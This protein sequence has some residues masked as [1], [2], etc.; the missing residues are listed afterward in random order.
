M[1]KFL[2][3]RFKTGPKIGEN[4][5]SLTYRGTFL[6]GEKQVIIK[7]YK[8]GTLNSALIKN[9]KAKVKLLS[10]ID[11]PGIAKLYDG[12]YGWQGFYYVRE[13]VEG[14]TLG[15]AELF[16]ADRIIGLVCEA[17][18][19]P[20]RAGLVHGAIKPEN[21]FILGDGQIKLVDFTIEGEVKEALPQKAVVVL[22]RSQFMSPEEI[23]GEVARAS[24]DIYSV[25]L[26]YYAMLT[27]ITDFPPTPKFNGP[28][29]PPPGLPKYA[30]DILDKA[31]QPDPLLRFRSIEDLLQSLKQKTLVEKREM[32]DFPPIELENRPP[33]EAQEV[34]VVRQERKRSFFLLIVI[35]LS[36]LAG[37]IYML[38]MRS[39]ANF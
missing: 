3:S 24:S 33:L 36:I 21:V 39:C 18:S 9:M 32:I 30:E 26:L 10:E 15:E 37:L 22:S 20:H 34:V 6:S 28:L 27:G 11:H 17:L 35:G 8:R 23:L 25:G 13:F 29:P 1:E 2:K 14:R 19:F 12:D 31:L 7:I 4:P 5:F 38:I 16:D